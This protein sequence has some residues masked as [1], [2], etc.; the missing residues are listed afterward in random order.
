MS[1][2]IIFWDKS[3]VQIND[4]TAE[5]LKTAIREET[6]KTFELENSLYSVSGIEKIIPKDQAYDIYPDQWE[7]L[8]KMDSK[9]PRR[10]FLA[11][12]EKNN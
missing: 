1:F 3:K 2:I 10:E 5:T 8:N 7:L 6:V 11:L 9:L 12:L 4:D